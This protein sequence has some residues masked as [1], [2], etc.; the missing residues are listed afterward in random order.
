MSALTAVMISAVEAVGCKGVMVLNGL[1]PFMCSTFCLIADSSMYIAGSIGVMEGI[2][3][4]FV[5]V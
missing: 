5:M 2:G 1:T 4:L 3:V